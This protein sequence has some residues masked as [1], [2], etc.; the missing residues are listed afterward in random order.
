LEKK[1]K[2]KK[3]VKEKIVKCYFCKVE[4]KESGLIRVEVGNKTKLMKYAHEECYEDYSDKKKFY[5]DLKETLKI[6]IIDKSIIIIFDRISKQG[7]SWKCFNM[8]LDVKKDAIM[9]NFHIGWPYTIGI[10]K[11][12]L[13]IVFREIEEKKKNK[14]NQQY[15]IDNNNFPQE[16]LPEEYKQKERLDISNLLD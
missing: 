9:D 12:T 3:V 14:I 11:K 7:Y 6:P 15:N 5:I 13:P 10:F 4:S 1:K 2:E 16:E 8:V